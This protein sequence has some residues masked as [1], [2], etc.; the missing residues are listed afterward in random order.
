MKDHEKLVV[1]QTYRRKAPEKC[2][3]SAVEGV[4][5]G[6]DAN[7]FATFRMQNH[8]SF[9]VDPTDIDAR[10]VHLSNA[11]NEPRSDCSQP[12]WVRVGVYEVYVWQGPDA[13]LRAQMQ[14]RG[15]NRMGRPECESIRVAN[16]VRR[17][18]RRDD[19]R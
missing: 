10:M 6:F 15:W 7:H 5:T 17:T 18:E 14:F 1:G 13:E 9:S 4:F 3:W 2:P 12:Q 11:A 19:E 8:H 16:A